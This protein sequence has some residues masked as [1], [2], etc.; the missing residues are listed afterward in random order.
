MYIEWNPNPLRSQIHLT[1]LENRLL[2]KACEA[3]QAKS[4]LYLAKSYLDKDLD[5]TNK[6]LS[7][8]IIVDDL[9]K[10]LLDTHC[11]DCT[12]MASSCTKCYAEWLLGIDTIRGL[13]KHSGN[14]LLHM[15]N[16]SDATIDSVLDRLKDKS[17]YTWLLSYK[18]KHNF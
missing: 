3:D 8:D 17:T 2:V 11:G 14:R 1:E 7:R 4:L 6:I 15:F 12:A 16:V 13:S 9:S 10:S 5:K 18:Q